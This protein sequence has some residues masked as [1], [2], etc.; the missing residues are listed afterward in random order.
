M[1][2]VTDPFHW[3][4][5]CF[6]VRILIPS[7]EQYLNVNSLVL[8]KELSSDIIFNFLKEINNVLQVVSC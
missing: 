4:I 6:F 2:P 1:S 7:R 5:F 8:F 3:N